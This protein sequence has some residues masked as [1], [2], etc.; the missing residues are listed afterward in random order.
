M[1]DINRIDLFSL[2][3]I[4]FGLRIV[5]TLDFIDL[6]KYSGIFLLLLI[7]INI[8]G[9]EWPFSTNFW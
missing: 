6:E 1:E 2:S 5:S 4:K 3:V 8:H 9:I 7:P